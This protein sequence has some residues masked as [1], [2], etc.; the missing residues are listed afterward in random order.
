MTSPHS[1]PHQ[2]IE[3]RLR[4]DR[5]LGLQRRIGVYRDDGLGVSLERRGIAIR[6]MDTSERRTGDDRR[7]HGGILASGIGS[8]LT[9]ER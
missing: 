8:L 4:R 9:L 6:A 2:L 5:R 3:R 7:F 1:R